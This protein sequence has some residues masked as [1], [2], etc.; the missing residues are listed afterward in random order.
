MSNK[1]LN[2][3]SELNTAELELACIDLI[4]QLE[5]L[6]VRANRSC[7]NDQVENSPEVACKMLTRLME[8]TVANLSGE[9]ADETR[10]EILK[11]A[12]SAEEH[13][14]ALSNRTLGESLRSML[15]KDDVDFRSLTTHSALG[16][17]L[18]KVS[19]T[20]LHKGLELLGEDTNSGKQLSL[21]SQAYIEQLEKEW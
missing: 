14:K 16:R 12:Q 13:Q 8:F 7:R 18:A 15:K 19:A 3:S 17:A 1:Q 5:A 21:S 10:G 9:A 6:L 20:T 11:V 4:C 2:N